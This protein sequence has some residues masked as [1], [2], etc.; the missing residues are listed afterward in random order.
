[1]LVAGP[2]IKKFSDMVGA[3]TYHR[4]GKADYT[5]VLDWANAYVHGRWHQEQGIPIEP[6][7]KER[8]ASIKNYIRWRVETSVTAVIKQSIQQSKL[9]GKDEHEQHAD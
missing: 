4:G 7:E 3:T 8:E 5:E 9:T 1:M 2:M 6:T